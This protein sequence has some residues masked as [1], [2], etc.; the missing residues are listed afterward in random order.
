M[1]EK[2][3]NVSILTFPGEFNFSAII[4]L[5]Y[6]KRRWGARFLNNDIEVIEEGWLWLVTHA[7]RP[8]SEPWVAGFIIRMAT[9]SMM[10]KLAWS[11]WICHRIKERRQRGIWQK[12]NCSHYSAVTAAALAIRKSCTM[13]LVSDEENLAVAFNVV[14][15]R[16]QETGYKNLYRIRELCH[17]GRFPRA[18]YWPKESGKVRSLL[19]K[20]D[21]YEGDP[22]YDKFVIERRVSNRSWKRHGLGKWTEH[23]WEPDV[24]PTLEI[25]GGLIDLNNQKGLEIGA[26]IPYRS[27]QRHKWW[28]EGFYLDLPWVKN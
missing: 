27:K 4:I 12:Y 25:L 8:T 3:D 21:E 6:R 5:R 2:N 24:G 17:H 10:N 19:W 11:R 28:R 16:V 18:W 15:L 26:L 13:R 9:S 20:I 23:G 22:H 7:S 14:Y 1:M